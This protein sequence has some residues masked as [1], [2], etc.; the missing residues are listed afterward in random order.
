M[1]E[2]DTL[3][4]EETLEGETLEVVFKCSEFWEGVAPPP[5]P[6]AQEVPR[7]YKSLAS[8]AEGEDPEGI[9]PRSI[10]RCS[11]FLDG[12]QAGYIIPLCTDVYVHAPENEKDLVRF[13]WGIQSPF[14][15]VTNHDTTQYKGSPWNRAYKFSSP[16]HIN[17][18]EGYTA[19]FLPILPNRYESSPPKFDALPAMV[20]LDVYG[21][22]VNYPFLWNEYPFEGFIQQGTPVVQMV[23]FRRE[24]WSHVIE[25]VTAEDEKEE[26]L[27]GKNTNSHPNYYK[28]NY[29]QPKLWR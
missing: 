8:M 21:A 7:W 18:P 17:L 29:R 12:L 22:I 6:A 4:E 23:P 19:L 10:K 11:P 13:S 14:P 24:L 9:P 25:Q 15:I 1:I 28:Q 16:W 5:Y 3:T 26:E 2:P 20:D 27:V